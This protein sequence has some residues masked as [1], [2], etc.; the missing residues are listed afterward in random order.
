MANKIVNYFRLFDSKQVKEREAAVAANAPGTSHPT[1]W[2]IAHFFC[3]LLGIASY[4]FVIAF[5]NGKLAS[6]TISIPL[7]FFSFIV[8]AAIFPA[9]FKKT[10]NTTDPGF[11]QLCVTFTS[12]IGYQSLF[13]SALNKV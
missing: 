10:F 7:I 8:A 5:Q 2:N 12:G 3:L 11:I 13:L 6:F 1:L 4:P 9:V